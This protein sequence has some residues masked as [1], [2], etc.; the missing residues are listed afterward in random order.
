MVEFGGYVARPEALA[1]QLGA[2][3]LVL[4]VDPGPTSAGVLPGKITEYIGLGRFV[5]ALAPPGEAREMLERYGNAV[6]AAADDPAGL[7]QAV[8]DLFR[9]W[10]ADPNLRGRSAATDVIPSR[11]DNAAR[12]AKLLNQVVGRRA[13][14]QPVPSICSPVPETCG[15][16]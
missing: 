1:Q 6:S 9:R 8:A 7:D 2:D 4:V 10:Q 12:L 13:P 5:L 15:V 14:V 11:R 3:A 16:A